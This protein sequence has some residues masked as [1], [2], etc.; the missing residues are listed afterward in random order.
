MLEEATTLVEPGYELPGA[1]ANSSERGWNM[2]DQNE[3]KTT[4]NKPSGSQTSPNPDESLGNQTRYGSYEDSQQDQGSTVSPNASEK[5]DESTAHSNT[6]TPAQGSST[7]RS[8]FRGQDGKADS[9]DKGDTNT[10]VT[11]PVSSRNPG[12]GSR[13]AKPED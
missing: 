11:N 8:P 1:M 5:Q 2:A 3:S 12:K 6:T 10:D 9:A 13:G 4:Q 7:S